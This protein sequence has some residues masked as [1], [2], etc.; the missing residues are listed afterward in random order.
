MFRFS[1][2]VATKLFLRN[3]SQATKGTPSKGKG[4]RNRNN[5]RKN[6]NSK[7]V[8]PGFNADPPATETSRL[9]GPAFHGPPQGVSTESPAITKPP[10]TA[11]DN[12]S[13]TLV[14]SS[15]GITEATASDSTELT[16]VPLE[17]SFT[18]ELDD[19]T[20]KEETKAVTAEATNTAPNLG[21]K[22]KISKEIADLKAGVEYHDRYHRTKSRSASTIDRPISSKGTNEKKVTGSKHIKKKNCRDSQ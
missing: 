14:S 4:N 22:K 2:M 11:S 21:Q 13:A 3:D 5:R 18:S 10:L 19:S 1:L 7:T 8:P 12:S 16:T 17:L 6:S 15:S 20:A 9:A